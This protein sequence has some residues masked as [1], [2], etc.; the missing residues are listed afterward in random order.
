[1]ILALVVF[2]CIFSSGVSHAADKSEKIGD[3]LQI[4]LPASA[5]GLS[6]YYQDGA[7]ALQFAESAALSTAVT[8]GL[9]YSIHD[10]RPNGRPQSFPSG[11]TSIS[12]TAAEFIRE[13]YGWELGIP[14]YALA[15]FVG[16]SRIDCKAHDY[17]DVIAGALI[18][19]GS[20]YLFTKPYEGWDIK[21]GGDL[22]NVGVMLSHKW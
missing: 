4:F 8:Q 3:A 6:L 1:L 5:L 10:A 20:S 9:K 19:I 22:K 15:S 14:A 13:R 18:G 17:D 21:V 11:H 7:G 12:F 16:Y 2:H